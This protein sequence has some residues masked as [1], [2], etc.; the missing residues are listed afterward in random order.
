MQFTSTLSIAALSAVVSAA[1]N[2]TIT[3]DITVTDYVTYCPEATTI[4]LTTCTK[5]VCAH[6]EVTVT[7]PATVTVT[8]EC[9]VPTTYTEDVTVT[10]TGSSNATVSQAP[11][12]TYEGGAQKQVAGALAGV[13]IVAALL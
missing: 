5:D 3:T 2:E 13:A 12:P 7:E 11:I 4:T 8:G 10:V 9:V 6:H 1:A